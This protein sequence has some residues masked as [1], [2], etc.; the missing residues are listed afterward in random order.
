MISTLLFDFGDVFINLDK[1]ASIRNL[2]RLKVTDFHE[3]LILLN[4]RYEKGELSSEEFL[5]TICRRYPH[6]EV[7]D[8]MDSWN[9][10]LLDFPEQRL[11][12]LKQLKQEGKYRLL[13]LSNTN[14]LHINYVKKQVPFFE[15]FQ[16]C[17]E[18][19]Y[20]SQ[21]MAMRKPETEIF[22][23]I[24][25]SHQLK[26][27]EVLFVDDTKENTKAAEKLGIHVWNIDPQKE[28][29]TQLFEVKGD[30]LGSHSSQK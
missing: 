24:L 12:F 22:E 6:L 19:F 9:S 23:F 14:D 28:D 16:E 21:Q 17:F 1:T 29:V 18:A 4:A 27:Q 25:E 20:L 3:D 10:I 13:L 15:E 8:V 5:T 11:D 30:L 2:E 26:P 7:E